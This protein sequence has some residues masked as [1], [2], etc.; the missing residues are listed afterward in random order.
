MYEADNHAF[1]GTDQI[2][3][4]YAEREAL[5]FAGLWRLAV[6]S[7]IP[8]TFRTDSST[9][10]NQA[11]G[12]S[13]HAVSHPT[14]ELLRGIFQALTA[15][16]SEPDLEVEHVRGHAGDVWNELVDFLAKTEASEGHRLQRQPLNLQ[17]LRPAIPYFWMILDSDAG[18][19]RFTLNGFD[20]CPPNLPPLC[21]DADVATCLPVQEISAHFTLSLASFEGW[22]IILEARWM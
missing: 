14:L 21:K 11:M 7:T 1:T 6:N 17:L 4:E 20:A 10:A 22:L 9:T 19:P 2:G 12:R 13:G 16:L 3:A 15:G 18:L 8:T 5:I